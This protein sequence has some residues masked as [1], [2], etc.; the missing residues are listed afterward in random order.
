[1]GANFGGGWTDAQRRAMERLKDAQRRDYQYRKE[2][3]CHTSP[4]C[5]DVEEAASDVARLGAKKGGDK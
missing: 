4:Y 1:M 5:G 2:H 3:Q